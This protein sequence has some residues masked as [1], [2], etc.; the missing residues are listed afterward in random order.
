LRAAAARPILAVSD[1]KVE[2][3]AV[4]LGET[5]PAVM[6]DVFNE[7]DGE[8]NWSATTEDPWIRLQ[9]E[10]RFF[11]L[12]FVVTKPGTYRGN[13]Y[14]RDS[15][16]GGSK[17]ISV[18]VQV[19]E[20]AARPELSITETS[21]DFGTVR[22]GSKIAPR[23][24]AIANK[25]SGDLRTNARS[26]N[27]S[28]RLS[29]TDRALTIDPDLS[30]PGSLAGDVEITSAGGSA[31]IS[32]TGEVEA[33]PVLGIQPGKT[34]DFGKESEDVL[35][36][37]KLT[38]VNEGSGELEWEFQV[39][40]NFFSAEIED[41]MSLKVTVA[42]NPP[43]D[44]I[45]T[46]LIKSNGGEATINVRAQITPSKR[47]PP[48]PPPPPVLVDLSGWWQ[49]PS[50]R[51]FVT[52]HPPEF[53]YADYNAFGMQVGSGVMRI[54]GVQVMIQGTSIIIQQTYNRPREWFATVRVK[55]N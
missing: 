54:E 23:V 11:R 18:F 28:L 5:L 29:L 2:L 7:G 19:L 12:K 3:D 22:A 16:R 21:I 8:L 53:Q 31:F 9:Q 14:V 6:I 30:R 43:G 38:L 4:Q 45:G 1:T 33:G 51:I 50:G 17:R 49:N 41:G 52:G 27:P 20:P 25:G 35:M 26:N 32:V 34:L 55:M 39:E 44:Y 46:I 40:G 42:G 47:N 36:W 13:I 48:P 15:G 37:K 24:V 10:A